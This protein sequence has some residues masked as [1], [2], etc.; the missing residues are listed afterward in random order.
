MIWPLHQLLF[1]NSNMGI[2][3]DTDEHSIL[4]NQMQW[5]LS[6][7]DLSVNCRFDQNSLSS[8]EDKLLQLVE[9]LDIHTIKYECRYKVYFHSH[10]IK[11]L[12]SAII[13]KLFT[14]KSIINVASYMLHWKRKKEEIK[15]GIFHVSS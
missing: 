11:R 3:K 6:S 8:L 12:C 1:L 4:W 2:W 10:Q 13:S 5:S 7:L 9:A 15:Q 14:S